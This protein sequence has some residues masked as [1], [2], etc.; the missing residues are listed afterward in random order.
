MHNYIISLCLK[1]EDI[2]KAGAAI[3]TIP[4][5]F[6][7]TRMLPLEDVCRAPCWDSNDPSLG[8]YLSQL[9]ETV[10][11]QGSYITAQLSKFHSIPRDVGVYDYEEIPGPSIMTSLIP[12]PPAAPVK[13]VTVEQMELLAAVMKL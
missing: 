5:R 12:P 13:A 3:V 2:A 1:V 8:N 11:F 7:N 10:R 4:D 6:D 9:C